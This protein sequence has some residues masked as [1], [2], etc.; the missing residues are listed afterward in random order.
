MFGN[1]NHVGLHIFYIANTFAYVSKGKPN[2][3]I[4][5]L[6]QYPVLYEWSYE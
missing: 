4:S 1:F 5:V 3:V 6:F 2:R